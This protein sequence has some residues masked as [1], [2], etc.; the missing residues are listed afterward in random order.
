MFDFS[1]NLVE[2]ILNSFN[3]RESEIK[4]EKY[5]QMIHRTEDTVIHQ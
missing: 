2:R 4:Q 5:L 3:V 1:S